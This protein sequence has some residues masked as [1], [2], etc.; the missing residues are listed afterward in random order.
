MTLFLSIL[1]V[2]IFTSACCP[3]RLIE[4]GV[5]DSIHIEI[6]ERTEYIH[7]TIRVEIPKESKV[8]T[9]KDTTS[10]LETSVSFSTASIDK[11]GTLHHTLENKPY[12]PPLNIKLPVLHR[13]SVIYRYKYVKD[14]VQVKK[15]LSKWVKAQI[16]GFWILAIIFALWIKKKVF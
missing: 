2:F 14:V 12:L 6:K 9:T 10:F 11:G 13:D 1:F 16:T 7:D 4:S 3:V 8:T 15:P 5:Q